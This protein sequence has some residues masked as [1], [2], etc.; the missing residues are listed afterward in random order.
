MTCFAAA[1]SRVSC[2]STVGIGCGPKFCHPALMVRDTQLVQ[3][4]G[5]GSH[6]ILSQQELQALLVL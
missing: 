2:Q 1:A 5:A 4:A 6:C 3:V